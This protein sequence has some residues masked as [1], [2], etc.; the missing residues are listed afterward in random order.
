MPECTSLRLRAGSRPTGRTF[1]IR[2]IITTM[3]PSL[4][5]DEN[6]A[7]GFSAPPVSAHG[8]TNDELLTEIERRA[9]LFFWEKAD[10]ITG[11]VNDRGRNHDKDNY[12]VSSIAAT[13][14]ALAALPIG[15]ERGWI[16]HDQALRRAESTLQCLVER[17]PQ[18]HG[19]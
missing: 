9:F 1:W 10:P 18:E 7:E 5:A 19:W 6:S 3:V 16:S 4:R 13:G 15:V 8:L 11:L 14:Y 12:T 2:S 17:T